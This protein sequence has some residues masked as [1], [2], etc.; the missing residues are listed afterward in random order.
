MTSNAAAEII[1]PAADSSG[2]E[3]NDAAFG[4]WLGALGIDCAAPVHI[5]RVGIGQSNL[6]FRITDGDNRRWVLR[7]PPL[8]RLLASAHDVAREARILSALA[9]TD[10]PVPRVHGLRQEGE[11]ALLLMEYV[12]GLV[13]DRPENAAALAPRQR[14]TAGISLARTLTRIHAVDLTATGLDGLASHKPYAPRQLKRWSAQ[15]DKSKTRELPALDRLT[16]RL[17]AAVP[18]QREIALVHGDYNIRNVI[19]APD[20][21]AVAAVLDWELSTLGDPLA[22]VGTL[23]AYWPAP[24]EPT[25][26]GLEMCNLPGFPSRDE[27]VAEYLDHTG[28]DRKALS[29]WHTL[30]VWKLAVI[31]EGVLRRIVDDPRNRAVAGAPTAELVDGLV[32][33]AHRIAS[34]AGL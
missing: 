16:E 2:F 30:A 10:V 5:E 3:L 20:T 33:T 23:L 21:S 4:A 8:G 26:A 25:F 13:I 29:Y 7:R 12:D 27:L 28:R 19:T 22:D 14:R 1:R 15:W 31:A 9:P 18:E 34:D 11:A 24:G 32:D 17:L 6:T